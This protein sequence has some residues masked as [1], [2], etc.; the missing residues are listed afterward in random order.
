MW[1]G[2]PIVLVMVDDAFLQRLSI[3]S[4]V[5][6]RTRQSNVSRFAERCA[7]C[8]AEFA[9][10]R[11]CWGPMGDTD[12][13]STFQGGDTGRHD[14]FGNYRPDRHAHARTQETRQRPA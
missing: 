6:G 4:N 9:A 14:W 5:T 11:N 1:S 13:V 7:L 12:R 2:V 3:P 8:G 10:N